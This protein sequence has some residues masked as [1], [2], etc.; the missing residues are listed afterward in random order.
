[1]RASTPVFPKPMVLLPSHAPRQL[2]TI[3]EL[4]AISRLS[5]TQLRRLARAGR[6][7]FYQPGGTGGRL[8]FPPDAIERQF[9]PSSASDGDPQHLPGRRP[10]WKQL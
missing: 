3:Q 6:I 2:L 9:S 4:S 10:Q 1:M 5:V 7:P 8:L